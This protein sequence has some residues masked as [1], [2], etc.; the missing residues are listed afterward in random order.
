MLRATASIASRGLLVTPTIRKSIDG[1][2]TASTELP[3]NDAQYTVIH[4]AMRLVV[5]EGTGGPLLNP[6][7]SVAAKTG[8]AQ[9]KQNTRVNSWTIGFFPAEQPRYAFTV[10]MENGPKVSSGAT[11]AMKPVITWF[12]EHPE[13]FQ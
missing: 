5:T 12:A 6:I 1:K 2:P 13:L 11:H 3:F 9:I 7:V 4:D 8:T 10:L